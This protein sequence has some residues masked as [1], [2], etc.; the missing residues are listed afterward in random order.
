MPLGTQHFEY[1]L[2]KQFF[3]MMES[4]DIHDANLTVNLDVTHKGDLYNMDF[5][6]DGTMTLECDRCL[7]DMECPVET[8]YSI[9][10]KYGDEYNDESD[11]LL[12]IPENENY[13]DVASLMYD[14][15]ALTIPIQHV[16][17]EGE[18]NSQMSDMLRRH[19]AYLSDE[20]EAE[21]D[22][23]APTDPRWDALKNLRTDGE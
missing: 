10:V 16:H 18:C 8:E 7:D 11:E 6:I 15:V 9:A 19:G 14:T 17:A 3:E 23:E 22:E 1:R 13:F 20:D 12:V 5:R 4:A 21:S 2:D